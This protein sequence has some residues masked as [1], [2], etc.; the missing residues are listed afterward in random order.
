MAKS[1]LQLKRYFN[2]YNRKHFNSELP[3]DTV[4]VWEPTTNDRTAETEK[5]P[6]GKFKIRLCPSISGLPKHAKVDLLHEM[7]HVKRGLNGSTN[8]FQSHGKAYKAELRRL[9]LAGAYDE[10]L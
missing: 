4:L 2:H 10:L 7:A 9:M 5:L 8:A 6:D 1:H 3:T